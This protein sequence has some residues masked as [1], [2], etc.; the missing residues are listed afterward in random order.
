M[1]NVLKAAAVRLRLSVT[2]KLPYQRRKYPAST[3]TPR[4]ICR[5][6]LAENSHSYGRFPHPFSTAGSYGRLGVDLPKLVSL[7]TPQ[8]SPPPDRWS[9]ASW[10]VRS[11]SGT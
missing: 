10:L 3:D 4:A 1:L 9:C 6:T 5:C 2:P 8:K 7:T 11:Q